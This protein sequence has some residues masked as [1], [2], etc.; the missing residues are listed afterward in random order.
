MS[1]CTKEELI[2]ALRQPFIGLF[3][4]GR[5]ECGTHLLPTNET[6]LPSDLYDG[7]AYL[8]EDQGAGE[9]EKVFQEAEAL[10]YETLHC[11]ACIATR[12]TVDGETYVESLSVS[13]ALTRAFYGSPDEQR[14]ELGLEARP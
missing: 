7:A 10:G 3:M 4:D 8:L 5:N 2:A 6:S 13:D 1:E 12:D 9:A 11:I 14:I